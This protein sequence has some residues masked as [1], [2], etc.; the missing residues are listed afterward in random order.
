MSGLDLV[1][2]GLALLVYPGGV[3][4]LAVGVVAETAAGLVLDRGGLRDSALRPLVRL[5]RAA[6]GG[7]RQLLGVV[8]LA[9]VAATQL[10]IPLNP[11]SPVERNLVVAAVA[12]AAASWLGRSGGWS[13]A[14]ARVALL[15]QGC[16]LVA[17]L[18]PA[19]VSESLR[20]QALGAVV[21]PDELPL[22]I[23]AG[24][25]A[26][27]CL[28]MLL[29]IIPGS[30]GGRMGGR[31]EVAIAARPLLWLPV[32]GLVASLFLPPGT[33]DLGGVLRFLGITLA[34]AAVA[35]GLGAA[36]ARAGPGAGRV[37]PRVLA[38]V[39]AAVL[40]IAI[41]TSGLA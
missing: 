12:L 14:G 6:A 16:W 35:I 37:Y 36:T 40:V 27:L 13:P 17:V 4:M 32:C 23:A 29:Q 2:H 33:E 1:L 28:P 20:P 31:M 22:K 41:A 11:V 30:S 38:P 15:A 24:L 39:A 9:A 19:L 21:V 25:L 26:V 34:A 10:A 5:R 7:V 3:L 8:L 18:A